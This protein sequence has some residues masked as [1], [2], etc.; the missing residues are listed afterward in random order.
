[1]IC[2]EIPIPVNMRESNVRRMYTIKEI[3]A[4]APNFEMLSL[5]RER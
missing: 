5:F 4:K 2:W 1:M 3:E